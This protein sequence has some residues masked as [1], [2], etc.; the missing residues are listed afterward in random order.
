MRWPRYLVLA[1]LFAAAAPPVR[2]EVESRDRELLDSVAR[3]LLAVVPPV[4][5]YVWPPTFEIVDED[6]INAYATAKVQGE[7]K[8]AKL[9][10]RIVVYQGLMKRVIERDADRLAYI[11]GHELGH[12]VLQHIRGATPGQ[13]TFV[14]LI[15][16]REQELAADRLGAELVLKA[17]Y[18]LQRAIK[19]VQK[20][21][22]LGSNYSSFEG[23]STD[24]PSW[25]D[26]LSFLDKDQA[27]LW[28]AMSAFQNGTYFLMFE[29]YVSAEQC[30]RQVIREF[31]RCHEAWTNLGYALLMRYCDAL[32]S[33]DVKDLD[34]GQI[35]VGGFYRRP[36]SLAE[37]TRGK[38]ET[39]WK[40]AVQ[41][42]EESLRLK[43]EQVLTKA[44]LGLAY[45][46]RPA[47]K[48]MAKATLY[49]S[50][51]ADR[52][53]GDQTLDASVRAALLINAGVVDLAG[54]RAEGSAQRF[55]LG[56][57]LGRTFAG[58]R[59]QAASSLAIDNAVLYN[60]ALLL[61]SSKDDGKRR[62]AVQL[63]EKYLHTANAASAWWPLAYER[64]TKLCKQLDIQPKDKPALARRSAA[65]FRFLSSVKL[66]SGASVSITEPVD[67]VVKRLGAGQDSPVVN[68]INLRR[69]RYPDLGI[70]LLAIDRVLA[71]SLVGA[72]APAL[73]L[74][75]VG[76]GAAE[77]PQLRIGMTKQEIEKILEHEDFDFRQLDDATVNLRFYPALGLAVRLSKNKVEELVVVQ[78]PR[79]PV[80]GE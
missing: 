49:L 79:Q 26:R 76:A 32:D 61:S 20:M 60:R 37:T 38:D 12:V 9:A 58:G 78:I 7:G 59:P 18:S 43:P 70:E 25:N 80:I 62:E 64:Y 46:V 3:R 39:I 13:T 57:K 27:G 42:L 72:K 55:D 51:A 68:K 50:E 21:N 16:G 15:Y 19:S 1:C 10:P 47:G 73:P 65:K 5:D 69:L 29:Q 24:H 66:T 71:V 2:A 11:L 54:G 77:A 45:L 67:D 53:A 75:S 56:E 41:A 48:D 31:P 44:N 14:K 34:V 23:L 22:D 4:P 36:D 35:L 63:F 8:A 28:K 6:K 17:G 52:A 30:F 74:Q 40:D 33:D